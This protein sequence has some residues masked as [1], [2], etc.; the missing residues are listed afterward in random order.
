MRLRIAQIYPIRHWSDAMTQ[1]V[2]ILGGRGRFGRNAAEA[3]WNRGWRVKLFD[4]ATDE[5]TTAAKDA[6]VIV[7]AWNPP[8]PQW[9]TEVPALTEMVIEA[10]KANDATVIVPGNVY[11]YGPDAPAQLSA[12][13][14]HNATNPLGRVRI[15][16]ED[17]YR[18]S[19]V[20]TIILRA[21]DFIDTEASGNWFDMVITAKAGK[22]T[23]TV[24]GDPDAMHAWA[25]LPDLARAAVLLAEKRA[26][27][28]RFEDVPFAG[29]TM[30]LNEM[31]RLCEDVL[32]RN[33]EQRDFGWL[34]IRAAGLVWPM[35]RHLVEMRYLWN[36]PHRLDGA[37]F[38]QLLPGFGETDPI[39]ALGVALGA[40][41]HPD[42]T[43]ATG[44]HHIAAE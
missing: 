6:D 5:L 36:K 2:L 17:A 22:G 43:V 42:E 13:T 19:G 25:Y 32:D 34:T 44:T 15:E 33:L 4:R 18:K 29:Y 35:G 28:D 31:Q 40:E 10:A 7:N 11:V 41:V 24:P 27:L 3:F 23:F 16:M 8:Y 9:E 12:S 26:L 14:P 37:R 20:Q 30:S 21:G 1:T 39:E 38:A